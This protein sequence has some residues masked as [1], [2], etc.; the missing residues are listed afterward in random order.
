MKD[1]KIGRLEVKERKTEKRGGEERKEEREE[2]GKGERKKNRYR[3]V[4]GKNLQR[5]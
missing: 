5:L 2:G 1:N 4:E 3:K